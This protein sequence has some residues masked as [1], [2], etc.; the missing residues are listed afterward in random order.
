MSLDQASP[1]REA[2]AT[3]GPRPRALP[4]PAV[5]AISGAALR[6]L[7]LVA[8]LLVWVAVSRAYGQDVVPGPADTVRAIIDQGSTQEFWAALRGT[9]VSTLL[10]VVLTAIV[11]VPLGIGI[12]VNRFARRSTRA[13]IDF[14]SAVPPVC[15]LPLV[16]LL[17]GPTLNMKLILI[18]YGAGLPLLVRTI[19]ATRD[20][21]PV[22]LDVCDTFRIGTLLKWRMVLVPSAL[23]GVLVGIRVSL[24]LALLLSLSCEYIGGVPGVGTQLYRAQLSARNDDAFAYAV[25]AGLIGVLLN[26]AMNWLSRAAIGWHPSVRTGRI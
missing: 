10:G 24:T 18:A 12:G 3:A 20:V 9:A 11:M 4:R 5:D 14:F 21:D 2:T 19:Y 13:T 8:C 26:V 15:F 7:G 22:L 23:P 6:V 16:L 17:F 25:I 1:P